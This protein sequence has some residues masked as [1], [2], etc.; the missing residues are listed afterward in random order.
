M[1]ESDWFLTA[2][3]YSLILLIQLQNCDLSEYQ[4]LVIRQK[5]IGQL[6]NQ[7]KSS[8]RCHLSR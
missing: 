3:I 1:L 5:K 8:S 4:E 7:W 6:K 2:H